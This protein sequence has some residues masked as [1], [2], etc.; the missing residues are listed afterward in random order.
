[1]TRVDKERGEQ[2]SGE[3]DRAYPLTGVKPVAC[4]APYYE[5]VKTCDVT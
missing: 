4:G 1:M 5:K 2:T 3:G